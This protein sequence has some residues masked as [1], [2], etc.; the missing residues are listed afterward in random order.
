MKTAEQN[1]AS[2]KRFRDRRNA[3][4]RTLRGEPE[5]IAANMVRL[6]GDERAQAI[7][8]AMIERIDHRGSQ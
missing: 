5:Q 7:A 8:K 1:A 4:A 2:Q 6:F 3:L